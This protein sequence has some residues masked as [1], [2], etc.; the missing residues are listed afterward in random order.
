MGLLGK[1]FLLRAFNSNS[2][3]E[4]PGDM[5]L[6]TREVTPADLDAIAV[7]ISD[8]VAKGTNVLW[9]IAQ[10]TATS[11]S[12]GILTVDANGTPVDAD[13]ITVCMLIN[14]YSLKSTAG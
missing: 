12:T 5:L 11:S 14:T 1:T 2:M 10:K 8:I 3:G 4:G 6:I 13:T 9:W 7:D